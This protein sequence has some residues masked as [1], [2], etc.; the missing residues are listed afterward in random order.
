MMKAQ[1]EETLM[2]RSLTA[3]GAFALLSFLLGILLNS[4]VILFD[5]I[6]STISI[7]M[8]GATLL[9]LKFITIRDPKRFP[10]GKYTLEP[11]MITVKYLALIALV[12][13]SLIAA[14]IALFSGGRDVLIGPGLAYA[15]FAAVYCY[16]IA[17][18]LKK[19]NQT[20]HSNAIRSEVNEWHLDF[21]V[22]TGI[23]AGFFIAYLMTLSDATAPFAVYADPVMMILISLYFMK[24]PISEIRQ[25]MREVLDMKPDDNVTAPV[26]AAVA[27]LKHAYGFEETFVRTT[28]VAKTLWLEIDIVVGAANNVETI[29][30]QDALR[31]QLLEKLPDNDAYDT[32]WLTMSFTNDRKWAI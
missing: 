7:V 24:W 28:L 32:V 12:F 18:Y 11:L 21:L 6:F 26:E 2:T 5:G 15:A 13:A 20:L 30:K 25:S 16:A 23:L 19:Q 10:F 3:V 29:D 31:E 1:T 22:S 4:Q 17:R 8:T 14:V 27:E 9:V